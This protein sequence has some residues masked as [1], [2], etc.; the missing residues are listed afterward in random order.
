MTVE[1]K[2]VQERHGYYDHNTGRYVQYEQPKY[3][4]NGQELF[5]QGDSDG[6]PKEEDNIPTGEGAIVKVLGGLG[7]VLGQ[8]GRGVMQMGVNFS[9]EIGRVTIVEEEETAGSPARSHRWTRTEYGQAPDGSRIV[10]ARERH[11]E[12]VEQ[13]ALSYRRREEVREPSYFSAPITAVGMPD[14]DWTSARR[15][16]ECD[17]MRKDLVMVRSGRHLWGLVNFGDSVYRKE[18]LLPS[19]IEEFQRTDEYNGL[20]GVGYKEL[21]SG[22]VK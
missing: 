4:V 15:S 7:S 11:F 8:V 10:T 16:D 13:Q 3:Y 9:A 2:R 20:I 18:G 1:Q 21:N 5:I 14:S 6:Q 22:E 17:H 19:Q 12:R